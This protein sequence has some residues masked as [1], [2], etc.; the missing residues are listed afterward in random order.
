[1]PRATYYRAQYGEPTRLEMALRCFSTDETTSPSEL[2]AALDLTTDNADQ[3]CLRLV[4]AGLIE[5]VSYGLYRKVARRA[6]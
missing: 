1:M 5:R 6:A 3:I 4:K 2:R